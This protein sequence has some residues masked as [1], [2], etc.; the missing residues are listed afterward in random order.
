MCGWTGH[1]QGNLAPGVCEAARPSARFGAK[2][3]PQGDIRG[4]EFLSRG[5]AQKWVPPK[6]Q[7]FCGTPYHSI[8][9]YMTK[10]WQKLPA[11]TNRWKISCIPKLG[12]RC[13]KPGR[14]KA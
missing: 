4:K 5:C 1:I 11:I 13:S 7:R 14:F 2:F 12:W 6:A 9:T 10:K 8:Y 3:C